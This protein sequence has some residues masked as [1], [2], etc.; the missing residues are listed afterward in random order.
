MNSMTWTLM[1]MRFQRA[2]F[3]PDYGLLLLKRENGISMMAS[4]TFDFEWLHHIAIGGQRL[5]FVTGGGIHMECWKRYEP[6]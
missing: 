2:V 3:S 1:E 6:G 5:V 4:G